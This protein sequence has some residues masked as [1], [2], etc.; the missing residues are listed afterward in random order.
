MN[1]L[2]LFLEDGVESKPMMGKR[3]E[4]GA[5]MGLSNGAGTGRVGRGRKQNE[6]ESFIIQ[7]LRTSDGRTLSSILLRMD[8]QQQQ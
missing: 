4:V 6:K 2:S 3:E 5:G 7:I 8:E 1:K